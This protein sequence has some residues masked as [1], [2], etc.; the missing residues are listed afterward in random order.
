M[1][2]GLRRRLAH[3]DEGPSFT[4]DDLHVRRDLAAGEGGEDPR[5]LLGGLRQRL[6]QVDQAGVGDTDS[7]GQVEVPPGVP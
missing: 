4:I 5:E 6:T 3:R 2:A 7:G 1:R